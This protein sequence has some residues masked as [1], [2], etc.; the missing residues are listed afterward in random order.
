MCD[1]R[2]EYWDLRNETVAGGTRWPATLL[3]GVSA[4]SVRVQTRISV[5]LQESSGSP[6]DWEY[7]LSESQVQTS[8]IQY[9]ESQTSL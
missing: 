2:A 8:H 9:Q 6:H 4:H 3:R 7:H 1:S 5:T